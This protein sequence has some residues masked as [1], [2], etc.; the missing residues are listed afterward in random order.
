MVETGGRANY[1]P[2]DDQETE[3]GKRGQGLDIPFRGI[4][5]LT[6]IPPTTTK[7]STTC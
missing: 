4:H 3:G 6:Q 7:G 1:S 5:T 2:Q